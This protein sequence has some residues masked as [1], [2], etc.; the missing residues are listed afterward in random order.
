M[1][2]KRK[3]TRGHVHEIEIDATPEAVWKAI[4][5]PEELANWFPIS[6]EASPGPGGTITYHWGHEFTAALSILE[7]TP[8]RHLRTTWM[9]AVMPQDSDREE[10]RRV[11]VDWYLEGAGGKTVLRLVHSGFDP[12]ASW[13]D[14]FDGTRR[15]WTY[16][17]RSLRHYLERHRGVRRRSF[18][19]RAPFAAGPHAAWE[20][21]TRRLIREGSAEGLRIGSPYRFTLASGDVVEGETVILLPPTDF[22]GTA[23]GLGDALWRFGYE[24][25]AGKAEL[26]LW[27]S[28][29]WQEAGAVRAL[30]ERWTKMLSASS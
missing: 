22:A 27:L 12:E 15:G 6:A 2:K 30:E 23:T 8:P 10:R 18:W 7:W 9:E 1:S 5:D 14:E 20:A 13:E 24:V 11:A 25:I 19:V 16:E 17:L 28:A 4:T 29:W 3:D 26:H 21:F